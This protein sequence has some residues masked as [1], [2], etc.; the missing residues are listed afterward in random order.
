MGI[1]EDAR[2]VA[3]AK[4]TE[5]QA[6]F[7]QT[8]GIG[9]SH[10][11][12][13]LAAELQPIHKAA[14][15]RAMEFIPPFASQS[16]IDL[17]ELCDAAREF[18][19][20]RV[21]VFSTPVLRAM[22]TPG[23][24]AHQGTVVRERKPFE[25]QI[26]EAIKNLKIGFVS[27]RSVAMNPADTVQAR[28]LKLLKAIYEQTRSSEEPVFVDQL[29]GQ[30]GIYIDDVRAAW[31]YLKDKG[32]IETF[33]V[34][35]T[36]RISASGVDAIEA[37]QLQPDRTTP[38]FPSITYNVT[39]HGTGAGSQVNV[40]SRGSTQVSQ[41]SDTDPAVVQQLVRGTRQLLEQMQK[42]L[43]ASAM[44]PT[45]RDEATKA[46]AELRSAS[47]DAKPDVGRLRRGLDS[48]GRI[49]ENAAGD[50]VATGARVVIL[51]LLGA[52]LP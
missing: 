4:A 43:P 51:S 18:L 29:G 33:N 5:I 30:L 46:I 12:L 16:Q 45:V 44:P 41:V 10:Y 9:H 6:K 42:M 35:Y 27:D 48:L 36:A 49:L 39:I 40:A 52:P 26:D 2:A 50:L 23:D 25:S 22:K 11:P 24:A 15:N 21:V 34:L 20:R 3:E 37:A 17:S 31:R 14:V 28:A 8:G 47:D 1:S 7:G 38:V 19:M 32:L 13:M